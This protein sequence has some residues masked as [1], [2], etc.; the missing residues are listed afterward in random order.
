MPENSRSNATVDRPLPMKM[1]PDLV[2][3][4]QQFSGHQHWVVKDPISLRYFHL[5]DEEY[6]IL[7][8]LDGHTSLR[9]IQQQFQRRFA[10]RRIRPPQLQSLLHELHSKG[11]V[12]VDAAHQDRQLLERQRRQRRLRWLETGSSLLALRFP[13]VDP[14]PLLRWLEPR[15]RWLFT[16][17]ARAAWLILALSAAGL[18]TIH[19]DTLLQR[20]P[21]FHS[22]FTAE[23][24][25]V[26]LLAMILIK[27]FHE[28]A[29]A[30]TCKYFGGE[31]HQIGVMLLV[32]TP[33]LYC[34]VSD[35]WLLPSKRQ[36]IAISA[37]GIYLEVFLA[38][39]CTFLWW[40][41]QPGL[42][43]SLALNIVM[44]CS[45]GT[46]VFNGNPLMRFDGYYIFADLVEIPNLQARS[47]QALSRRLAAWGL[48]MDSPSDR[49]FTERRGVLL[50]SYAVSSLVYRCVVIVGIYY[51]L[52]EV[53]RPYRLQFLAQAF[54]LVTIAGM[55]APPAWR[56]A[57]LLREPLMRRRI[58]RSHAIR[59]AI[60]L[61]GLAVTVLA[62]PLPCRVSAP[63]ALELKDARPV[64]VTTAG[65]VDKTVPHGSRVAAG[66]V[67]ARLIKP[68]TR[69]EVVELTSRRDRQ[70]QQLRHLEAR[71]GVDPDAASQIPSARQM[72]ADLEERLRQLER[73]E[74][75]LELRAPVAGHVIQPPR[76]PAS[77]GSAERLPTW[78]GTPLDPINRGCTLEAGLL[79]C[80]VGDPERLEA[81][82][83]VDQ[84]ETD[85]IQSGQ[86]VKI[87]LDQWPWKTLRG[88]VVEISQINLE[89]ASPALVAGG[90][91]PVRTDSDG[92]SRPVS[93]VYQ[94]RIDLDESDFHALAG[95][96]GRCK[97]AVAPQSIARRLARYVSR[98]F[99][100]AP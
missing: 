63:L 29:H 71:R 64:Y 68:E 35:A 91:I 34:D 38:S 30:V 80:L 17:A 96:S 28:L 22:F 99:R 15:C 82:A 11:L 78:T 59:S 14:E 52:S 2:V 92:V 13:G 31:C 6:S 69:M 94:A 95:A 93:T 5:L 48:G 60:V 37:A 7:R 98:N 53:L 54:I 73:Y 12:L 65:I 33:C 86:R 57:K 45:V 43:N 84:A 25:L 21:K 75:M 42:L 83:I 44:L 79:F 70:S 87:R 24:L 23:N 74:D 8:M 50:T 41:T 90:D 89:V 10:P 49:V 85:L 100:G 76:V 62:V 40:Y 4:P 20:L 18:A 72:L 58:R 3:R 47:R 88:T 27:V 66:D 61:L 55:I 1:R 67:L 77:K 56:L 51:F 36:R 97:I 16:R 39:V 32:F 46:L 19:F 9:E 26:F 81:V